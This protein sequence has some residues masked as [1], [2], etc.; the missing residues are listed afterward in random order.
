MKYRDWE[1]KQCKS[2]KRKQVQIQQA[3]DVT[4]CPERC[5]S[6]WLT[7]LMTFS[8][9]INHF[10]W[11][12]DSPPPRS[13]DFSL[14]LFISQTPN[15]WSLGG[16]YLP[17]SLRGNTPCAQD[18][19]QPTTSAVVDRNNEGKFVTPHQSLSLYL[20][21]GT[22]ILSTNHQICH[23]NQQTYCIVLGIQ[24]DLGDSS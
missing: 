24:E 12:I 8:R 20:H 6:E 11:N 7:I 23:C 3:E 17:L 18:I 10:Y 5:L 19:E 13:A 15:L 9:K 2:K 4:S 14:D 22:K 16:A 1:L 21:L